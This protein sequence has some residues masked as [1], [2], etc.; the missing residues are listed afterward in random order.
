[1]QQYAD[2]AVEFKGQMTQGSGHFRPDN[3]VPAPRLACQTFK[4]LDLVLF[5]PANIAAYKSYTIT[6]GTKKETLTFKVFFNRHGNGFKHLAENR[7]ITFKQ[8]YPEALHFSCK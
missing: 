8:R 6:T 4:Q 5:Q 7:F 3:L 2:L 1:M